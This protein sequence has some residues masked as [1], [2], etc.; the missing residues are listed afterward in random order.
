MKKAKRE[1][2]MG[3]TL[4]IIAAVRILLTEIAGLAC[5]VVYRVSECQN[6]LK[7]HVKLC[8]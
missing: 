2:N 4:D 8:C 3:W 7:I 1:S 6:G 5:V